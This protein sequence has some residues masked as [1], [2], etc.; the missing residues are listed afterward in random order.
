MLDNI[1]Q[2]CDNIV[3]ML[4]F[5]LKYN[6]GTMFTQ[7]CLV[8]HTMLLGRL[9]VSTNEHRHNVGTDVET[10]LAPML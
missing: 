3:V 2:R 6:I 9:K 4:G 5:W 8:V 7:H 10:V 1:S